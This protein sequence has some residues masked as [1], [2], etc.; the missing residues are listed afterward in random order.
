MTE[1]KLHIAE[2][3]DAPVWRMEI[4]AIRNLLFLEI[5]DIETREVSFS[6]IDLN[7][8]ETYFRGLKNDER[9]LTGI[10]AAFGGVLLIHYYETGSSPAHK[11]MAAINGITGRV[12]WNNY[13]YSFDHLT[14][15]G[16][17]LF[18]ARM[19]PRRFLTIDVNTG[20]PVKNDDT[21]TS[22]SAGNHIR[23]PEAISVSALSELDFLSVIPYGN[24]VQHLDYNNYRIVSLHTQWAGQLRQLL[25]IFENGKPVFEDLLNAD[26]QKMQPEAFVMYKHQLIYL[27]NRTEVQVLNL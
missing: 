3:F 16:P 23:L 19:Q 1:I 15:N 26:I 14:I 18:D 7:T 9:W 5:R 24:I 21:A 27:K 20:L 25:Y 11:G 22:Q 12:L 13:N 6:S 8:A 4:D 17:V 10:E 2:Y